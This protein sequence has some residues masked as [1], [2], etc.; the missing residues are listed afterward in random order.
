MSVS[1]VGDDMQ[2][3]RRCAMYHHVLFRYSTLKTKLHTGAVCEDTL[4]THCGA[5]LTA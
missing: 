5:Q 2:S 3:N 1:F 4:K